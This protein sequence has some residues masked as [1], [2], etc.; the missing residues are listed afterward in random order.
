MS[1]WKNSL[2]KQMLF[3]ILAALGISGLLFLG[4][5]HI[6]EYMLDSYFE[7]SSFLKDKND[8]SAQDLKTYIKKNNVSTK[9]IG[10]LDAWGKKNKAVYYSVYK[11]GELAYDSYYGE[12]KESSYQEWMIEYIETESHYQMIFSDGTAE[13]FLLG[14]YDYKF[15]T[16]AFFLEFFLS[17]IVFIAIL[18]WFI[19]KK[20]NY[21]QQIES[22]IKILEGGTL[23]KEIT[24]KGTDELSALA[25][26][27][28]EMRLSLR[29]NLKKEEELLL[30]NKNLITGMSHDL[31][32]P[33]TTL[34]IYLDLV[35]TKKYKDQTELE[36]YLN[37]ISNKAKQI[38]VLSDQLFELCLITNHKRV[39]LENPQLIQYIFE[40]ILSDVI[41]FLETQGFQVDSRIEWKPVHVSVN[42]EYIIRIIDNITSNILK[43]ADKNMKVCIGIYYTEKEAGI[44]FTNG[45]FAQEGKIESTR[46]GIPNVRLMMKKMDGDCRIKEKDGSYTLQL[47]FESLQ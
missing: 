23:E 29:Q 32:T 41:I 20:I 27:L 24:I 37:I 21:V 42:T 31:R 18:I 2:K 43:Y 13:V 30:A 45:V 10:L 14:F 16:L 3:V 5:F 9:D 19:Q 4:M 11:D 44:C 47:I 26:G 39:N 35:N 36:K 34:I 46:I 38:Q 8:K 40:D 7:E 22:E 6:G 17:T 28:N 12:D 15:Y 1:N 25:N 33:L